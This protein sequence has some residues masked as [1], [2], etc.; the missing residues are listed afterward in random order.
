M[1]QAGGV[2]KAQLGGTV[3]EH[4]SK[5][6]VKRL[7]LLTNLLYQKARFRASFGLAYA[8]TFSALS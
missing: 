4:G 5:L 7:T 2:K 8:R 1:G 6:L 3:S